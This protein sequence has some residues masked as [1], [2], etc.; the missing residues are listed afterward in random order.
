MCVSIIIH[1][2]IPEDENL[3]EMN[4]GKDWTTV[5][6]NSMPVN[7]TLKILRWQEAWLQC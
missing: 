7:C 6:T 5:Y 1:I 3:L 4:D 2:Y